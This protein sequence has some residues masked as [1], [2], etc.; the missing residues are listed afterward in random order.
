MPKDGYQIITY[1]SLTAA[2][3]LGFFVFKKSL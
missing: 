3:D 1:D 2:K